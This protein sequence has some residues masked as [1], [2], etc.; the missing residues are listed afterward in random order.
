MR[1]GAAD[2]V[3]VQLRAVRR[4]GVAA[5]WHRLGY[6]LDHYFARELY[7]LFCSIYWSVPS[8]SSCSLTRVLTFLVR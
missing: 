4:C 7:G 6:H 3:H 5:V 8:F 2:V 1:R